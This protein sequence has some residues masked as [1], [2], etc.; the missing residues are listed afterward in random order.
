MQ[1]GR[2][3]GCWVW[4]DRTGNTDLKNARNT[5]GVQRNIRLWPKPSEPLRARP[6]V[7]LRCVLSIMSAQRLGE[8]KRQE[9]QHESVG[10]PSRMDGHGAGGELTVFMFPRLSNRARSKSTNVTYYYCVFIVSS[11]KHC[12]PRRRLFDSIVKKYKNILND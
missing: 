12:R 11:S 4:F 1:S 6:A 10:F 8:V 5:K 3:G 2:R 9:L 7:S